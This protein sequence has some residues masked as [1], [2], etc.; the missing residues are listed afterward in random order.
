[1]AIDLADL[2]PAVIREVNAPGT[3]LFTGAVDDDWL[4]QLE[5]SFWEAK[6]F[7]FFANFSEADGLV[8]PITGTTEL[9]RDWQQLIVLFA[10]IRTLRIKLINQGTSFHAKAGPVEITTS[11]S[12]NLMTLAMKQLQE[13]IT[14]LLNNLADSIT[15][16]TLVYY[17]NGICAE[18]YAL[19]YGFDRFSGSDG[20]AGW[21]G[22]Y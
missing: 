2:I 4:G 10:G 3:N 21:G 6:L 19:Q 17:I 13:K 7:G 11:N 14:L 20:G 1:M 5:D 15:G 12:A 22:G 9:T 18:T 16:H 8:T